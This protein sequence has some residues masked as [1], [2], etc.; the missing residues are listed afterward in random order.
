MGRKLSILAI[1]LALSFGMV[2]CKKQ[3][4]GDQAQDAAK[5]T[6]QDASKAAEDAKKATA[7]D[8]TK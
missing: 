6:T 3:S 4:A 5:Q 2:A 1:L 7:D 8:L